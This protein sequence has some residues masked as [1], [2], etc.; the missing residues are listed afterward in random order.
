MCLG[1]IVKDFAQG[2]NTSIVM[3]LV[4]ASTFAYIGDTIESYISVD[5]CI[6]KDFIIKECAI[7]VVS[8]L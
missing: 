2:D 7:R 6:G 5:W 4:S 1:I 3:W 8:V